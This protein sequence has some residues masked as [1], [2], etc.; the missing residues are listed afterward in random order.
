[1]VMP[2][3]MK[4]HRVSQTNWSLKWVKDW[5]YRDLVEDLEIGVDWRLCHSL[6]LPL[7]T[8]ADILDD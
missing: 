3:V 6:L 8:K 4:R 2:P 5:D 7:Q 1:M